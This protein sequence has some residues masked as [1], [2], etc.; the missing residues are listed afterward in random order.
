MSFLVKTEGTTRGAVPGLASVGFMRQ[1]FALTS[2][3]I[4]SRFRGTLAGAFWVFAFP[5]LAF[6]V[7]IWAYRRVLDVPVVD[8]SSFL[9]S[10]LLPW[11]WI[12]QTFEMGIASLSLQAPFFRATPLHPLAGVASSVLGNALCSSIP[13]LALTLLTANGLQEAVVR[14]VL[15]VPAIA[16]LTAALIPLLILLASFQIFLRD[17]RFVASFVMSLL[18]FLTPIFYPEETVPEQWRGGLDWNPIYRLILPIRSAIY[19]P[20]RGDYG[21]NFAIAVGLVIVLAAGAFPLWAK[22]RKQ[23]YAS[24]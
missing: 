6:A 3:S 13:L 10:A 15:L 21:M 11:I 5:L 9:F 7:Q 22:V 4:R 2:V 20:L 8:Y 23:V 1:T 14:V 16:L 24:A 18:Y 12:S 17:T 19:E